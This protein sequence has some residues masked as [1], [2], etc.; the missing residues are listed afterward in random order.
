M[1]WLSRHIYIYMCVCVCVCVCVW[2]FICYTHTH[3]ISYIEHT[4]G[5]K[6]RMKWLSQPIKFM[7]IKFFIFILGFHVGSKV[8]SQPHHERVCPLG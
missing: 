2:H 3:H 1:K 8:K 4:R 7:E 5:R 6:K